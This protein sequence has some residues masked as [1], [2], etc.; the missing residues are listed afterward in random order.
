MNDLAVPVKSG[1]SH[2]AMGGSG[3]GVVHFEHYLLILLHRKWLIVSIFLFVSA[4]TVIV[5]YKLPN[6]YTSETLILVDPQQVPN[7]Y[8]RSTVSGDVRNRLSTLSQQILSAT[9]LQKVI[10]TFSLYPEEKKKL[11]QED[12]IALMRKNITVNMVGGGGG[13]QDL[14]AFKITYASNNARIA[15]QVTNELAS[16]FIEEN[17]NAREQLTTGTTEFLDHQLGETRKSLETL[18]ARIGEFK[19][20][21]LGEMPEQQQSNIQ[22]LAQLQS[23]LQVLSDALYRAQQQRSYLQAL[24]A[25][26]NPPRGTSRNLQSA[27]Q[28]QVSSNAATSLQTPAEAQLT[29][30][31]SRYGENYPDVKRL[32]IQIEEERRD[33]EEAQRKTQSERKSLEAKSLPSPT[34]ESGSLSNLPT[35]RTSP[36]IEAQLTSLEGEIAKDKQDQQEIIKS[37]S[38]YQQKM[39][40]EPVRE[41][42]IADLIRDYA[43][44]KDHYSQLLEKKL[45]AEMATQLEIRQKGEKFTILDPAQVPQRPSRPNRLAIDLAGGLVGLALGLAAALST[46]FFGMT[47]ISSAQINTA[48]GLAVL[49]VIPSISTRYDR[50]RRKRWM[51]VGAAGGLATILAF[52]AFLFYH[53]RERIF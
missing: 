28:P 49:G 46:E 14:Q 21:H 12:V 7:D 8:V 31:L 23:R 6:V 1:G 27:S 2:G 24:I 44:S 47:I 40:A 4:G 13:G 34:A 51:L 52:C 42:E 38:S 25:A 29:L 45:S 53:Y 18:E 30:M 3:L 10:E 16:L 41:Q 33:R 50:R 26:D 22:I 36:E 35:R 19:I 37:I 15:A 9:R 32:R 20:K 11:H 17:L 39:E 5:A 43:I 48:L